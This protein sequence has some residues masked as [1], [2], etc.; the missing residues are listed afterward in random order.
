ML[1]ILTEKYKTGPVIDVF[2]SEDEGLMC[3]ETKEPSP[4]R[5]A[6]TAWIRRSLGGTQWARQSSEFAPEI[7]GTVLHLAQPED[8]ELSIGRPIT[9]LSPTVPH[10]PTD[11]TQA[12][13]IPPGRAS[14]DRL[15]FI[16]KAHRHHPTDCTQASRI[17]PGCASGES[18]IGFHTSNRTLPPKRGWSNSSG[19]RVDSVSRLAGS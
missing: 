9:A 5:L 1:N 2:V 13:R 15:H 19:D 10:H 4:W 6:N 17:P 11:G 16:L 18:G 3:V 8:P 14:G 7:E 12:S